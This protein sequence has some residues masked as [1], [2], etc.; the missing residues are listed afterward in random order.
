MNSLILVSSLI[1]GWNG[2]TQMESDT[3]EYE[4]V[5]N[6][7]ACEASAAE[8]NIDQ[9]LYVE[10]QQEIVLGFDT[11]EYL[12]EN[13]DAH[14]G[15]LNDI[16][17]IEEEEVVLGFDTA[18]YL[19]ENFDAYAGDLNDIVYVE[20]E[21]EIIL[22]FDTSQYLPDGFDPHITNLKCLV[23]AEA[24]EEVALGFDTLAWLPENFDPHVGNL[25]EIKYIKMDHHF[26]NR[27]RQSEAIAELNF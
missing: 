24:E 21:E 14:A 3:T 6:E 5:Y 17:F 7:V 25:N 8:L 19:P 22:G 16:A 2:T 27:F 1:L 12:P 23:Y 11:A 4:P 26:M 10:E 13:F 18:E 20:E 15:N 9:I